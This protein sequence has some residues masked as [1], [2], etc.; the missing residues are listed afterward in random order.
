MIKL[1]DAEKQIITEL[2]H[3]LYTVDFVELW[4]NRNDNVLINPAAALQAMGAKGYYDAVHQMAA[5]QEE[6]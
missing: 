1:T 4:I 5:H 2:G 6:Q 3:T